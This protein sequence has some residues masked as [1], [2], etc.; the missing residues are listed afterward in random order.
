M[1]DANNSMGNE[2]RKIIIDNNKKIVGYLLIN[3]GRKV[4]KNG[5][6]AIAGVIDELRDRVI[7]INSII[8]YENDGIKTKEKRQNDSRDA[9]GVKYG[10][11]NC[12]GDGMGAIIGEKNISNNENSKNSLN[13][14]G[15][16]LYL[17]SIV[18]KIYSFS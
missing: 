1:V 18:F 3:E 11:D 8:N 10:N 4:L 2:N 7:L 15:L 13:N 9:D 12:M 16:I 17:N 5:I 6:K 14:F